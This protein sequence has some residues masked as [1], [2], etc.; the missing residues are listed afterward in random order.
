[1]DFT[2]SLFERHYK[3]FLV[4]VSITA[5]I[6]LYSKYHYHHHHKPTTNPTTTKEKDDIIMELMATVD[7][8]EDIQKYIE[9]L[10]CEASVEEV[11]AASLTDLVG[12]LMKWSDDEDWL[13]LVESVAVKD[14]FVASSL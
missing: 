9:E 5:F 11:M 12:E 14:E 3:K 13:K 10:P 6:G 8:V 7:T 1:M 2:S 4:I